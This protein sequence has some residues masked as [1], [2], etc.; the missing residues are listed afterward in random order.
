MIKSPLRYP[1]GKSKL[2]EYIKRLIISEGLTGCEFYE[3]YAGG[4]SVSINLLADR[5]V[6]RIIINEKDPLVYSFWYSVFFKT[7]ELCDLIYSTPITLEKWYEMSKY[8]N[9]NFIH[10]KSVVEMGFACLFL[11]RTNFSGILN[12][13]MLGG[14]KQKSKYKIDCRFN[15][16]KIIKL[17]NEIS[18]MKENVEVYNLDAIDFMKAKVPKTYKGLSFVYLDPPYYKQGK[19]LYRYYYEDDEHIILSEYILKQPFNWLISYDKHD[20]IEKLYSKKN[21]AIRSIYFDYSVHTSKRNQEEI[22]ISNLEIPPI[23]G[24]VEAKKIPG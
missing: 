22:L 5:V 9:P 11:N 4:A 19:K 23:E 16:E 18:Q 1:G 2:I 14:T 3:V 20:F 15:K 10:D 21:I 12:A 8:R 17:I 7:K 13:N 6:K 24:I